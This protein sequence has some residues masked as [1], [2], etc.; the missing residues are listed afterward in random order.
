[1]SGNCSDAGFKG[2]GG[3][4]TSALLYVPYGVAVDGLGDVY[5]ADSNNSVI[6]LVDAFGTI[7]TEAGT[8]EHSGYGGDGGPAMS[9]LLSSP[10]A[11]AVDG[12]GN[13]YI[14]DYY[15]T[16]IRKVDPFGTIT[17]VAGQCT[18]LFFGGC[19]GD[20]YAGDGGPATSA[21]LSRPSGVAVDGS[22]NLFIADTGNSV[23]RKVDSSGIITTF[24]GIGL[25]CCYAGD[26]GPATSALLNGPSGVAVDGNGNLYIADT[27]NNVIR[28]V[29]SSGTISTVAGQCGATKPSQLCTDAGYSGDGGPA[30]NAFLNLPNA[31]AVDESGNLY[32]ADTANEVIRKVDH[33]GTITTVAG[34][35]STANYGGDGGPATSAFLN[36]PTGVAVDGSGNLFI[37]DSFNNVIR[38]V[39]NPSQ[40]LPVAST[41]TF[42]LNPGTYSSAQTVTISDTTAGTKIYYTTDGTVPTSAS[43][44]YTGTLT[45]LTS[46]TLQAIA[47]ATNYNNSAVGAAIYAI[48]APT[49]TVLTISPSSVSPGTSVGVTVTVAR[50]SGAGTPTGSVILSEGSYVVGTYSLL[51][52]QTSV[53]VPIPVGAPTGNYSVTATYQGDGSDQTSSGRANLTIST[54]APTTTTLTVLPGSVYP[55]S[56]VFV[57]A[58][59]ARTDRTATP[60]GSVVLSEGSYV[61]GTY[62]LSAGVASVSVPVPSGAPAGSYT[63]TATYQGDSLDQTSSGNATL[64][65]TPLASTITGLTFSSASVV[66]GDSVAVTATVSRVGGNGTPTGSII[67]VEGSYVIGTFPLASGVV[68]VSIPIPV[69]APAGTYTV[70]ATYLA[71]ASDQTSSAS[72]NLTITPHAATTTVLSLS[73]G[74]VAPGHIVTVWATVARAGSPVTPTGSVTLS[75]GSYVIGTFPLVAGS[76]NTFVSVPVGAPTGTYTVTATYPGDASDLTSSATA[77][78]SIVPEAPVS[79]AAT[80]GSGQTAAV[81]I[82][83]PSQLQVY[84]LDTQGNPDVG[85]LVNFTTPTSGASATLS[86]SSCVTGLYGACSVQ[87]TANGTVGTYTVTATLGSLSASFSLTNAGPQSYVVTVTSDGTTGVASNCVDQNIGSP[88]ANTNCSLRDALAAAAA[89]ASSASSASITFAQTTP[90][91]IT[92]LHGTLNIPSYTTI[93]GATSGS[94]AS[95][96]NLITVDG[97]RSSTVF[98]EAFQ[99]VHTAINNLT[100]T[101]GLSYVAGGGI[102]TSGN[103][104]VSEC[105]FV[106][107]QGV[108]GG[109]IWNYGGTLNVFGSTF[110]NNAGGY[111]GGI[112]NNDAGV[113]TISN[114]T[115]TGN[116]ATD[117]GAIYS[118]GTTAVIDS[119]ITGN[120]ATYGSGVY[121]L[122]G[123]TVSGS[124]LGA[125]N[126]E[127]CGGTYCASNWVYVEFTALTPNPI[128]ASGI[129][130]SFTD[131]L[132]NSFSQTAP[133][134]QFDSPAGIAATFGPYFYENESGLDTT[135]ITAEGLGSLLVI[136]PVNGATLGPLTIINPGKSF[137]AQQQFAPYLL[138]TGNNVYGQTAA[139]L[140][141]S[142]LGHYGGPTQTMVPLT[143]STAL[144]AISPSRATGTDQRGNPRSAVSGINTCQDAG[145]VQTNY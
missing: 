37:A 143:G 92:L 8:G 49:K 74:I 102:Y 140:N 116:L 2:D 77:N 134:G 50:V 64:T 60:K 139:Q 78:L 63:V 13:V 20:G 127:E 47:T 70:T 41:P 88:T 98:T 142:P 141:L 138:S 111:G 66:P 137:G 135:P 86:A 68:S 55:G 43:T 75:E 106:S 1:V 85:A 104:S 18:I 107:N 72:R 48:S 103:L 69:G 119:T 57:T 123:M 42:S 128:D 109:G 120:T 121:N 34:T 61:I 12:V 33:S 9:A 117:G 125:N 105:T 28:K 36:S 81:G 45:V 89:N 90:S 100:I 144:C 31:V 11:V 99:V 4:A 7:S 108:S 97:N 83:F 93:Q 5:I 46:E 29:D 130:I 65:I 136:T 118:H 54:L 76:T 21:S 62:P 71:D 80:S 101:N 3:A 27:S 87:A 10:Y 58:T 110:L 15:N 124:L 67:L 6:R 53:S 133:Y 91:T 145:A 22:G 25:S 52:G 84:V 95:R 96:T 82:P 39:T 126:G 44:L 115:F 51:G 113:A 16:R 24:A 38:K 40:P 26:G 35:G 30:T 23:I 17:T 112:D 14:A 56:S 32:I 129:T 131:S 132:G 122:Q 59:V 73:P 114:S 19:V 94:G 79:L